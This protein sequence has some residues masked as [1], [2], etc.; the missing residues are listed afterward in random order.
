MDG[1]RKV[2]M[3]SAQFTV[4]VLQEKKKGKKK[5]EETPNFFIPDEQIEHSSAFAFLSSF[6][7]E[8]VTYFLPSSWVANI[9]SI[10]ETDK[11]IKFE[12]TGLDVF[13]IFSW[14]LSDKFLDDI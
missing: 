2:Y 3:C 10:M 13:V 12:T 7:I 9:T 11:M 5:K 6:R 4:Q 1:N 14:N 8:G